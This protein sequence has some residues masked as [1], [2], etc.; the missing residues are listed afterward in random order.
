M[1]HIEFDL[2]MVCVILCNSWPILEAKR[3]QRSGFGL[4]CLFTEIVI[5]YFFLTFASYQPMIILF[6]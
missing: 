5:N 3:N 1:F 6:V 2:F 4:K